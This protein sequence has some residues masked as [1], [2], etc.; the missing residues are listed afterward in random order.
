MC[1]EPKDD[2]CGRV[3]GVEDVEEHV[4]GEQPVRE[5]LAAAAG[6]LGG[7][8]GDGAADGKCGGAQGGWQEGGEAAVG[9]V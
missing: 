1:D 7:W 9:Q 6:A 3:D 5:G 2:G 8:G 4:R